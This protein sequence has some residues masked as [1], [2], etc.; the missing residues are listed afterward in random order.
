MLKNILV[1]FRWS[2]SIGNKFFKVVPSATL[3]VVLATLI[4]QFSIVLAFLLPLKVLMLL[5][6]ASIPHYFPDFL[7][8]FDHDS[9][10]LVL[11]LASVGFYLVY[12]LAEKIVSIGA[13]RGA[14]KL[15][16]R[17]KK[18]I[19]FEKQDEVASQAYKSYSHSLA[20]GV[21]VVMIA[22]FF[23]LY[24]PLLL[25]FLFVYVILAFI[26]LSLLHS[27]GGSVAKSLDSTPGKVV[28]IAANIGFLSAFV[29]IVGLFLFGYSPGFLITMVSLI[30]MRQG[31]SRVT[32]VVSGIKG[33]YSQ[34]LKLNALFFHGHVFINSL[35]REQGGFWQI[36]KLGDL[37]ESLSYVLPGKSRDA[38]KNISIEWLQNGVTDVVFLVVCFGGKENIFGCD[39]YLVKIFNSNRKSQAMHEATLLS[40]NLCVPALKLTSVEEIKGFQC[41]ILNFSGTYKYSESKFF[42]KEFLTQMLSIEPQEKIIAR[43]SRSKEPLWERINPDMLERLRSVGALL[44]KGYESHIDSFLKKQGLFSDILSGLPLSFVNPD[45][46]KDLVLVDQKDSL[47]ALHW[48]RWTLEPVGAGWSLASNEFSNLDKALNNAKRQRSSL[49]NVSTEQAYLAALAYGFERYFSRQQYIIA[50]DLLVKMVSCLEE[51]SSE[52]TCG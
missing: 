45:V 4:A 20:N 44:E 29:Y 32:A 1:A 49:V 26:S 28:N 8:I 23:A 15:L 14:A 46:S 27:L 31:S 10:V 3:T 24:Y 5:G 12:F 35:G 16:D 41:H 21:F 2:L 6:S 19:L 39:K 7:K 25:V 40:E 48:G 38:Y 43:Y 22:I 17:N 34:R 51:V 30:L 37:K 13:R 52:A 42:K 50:L 33:L 9:L 18:V 36:I 11:C 47:I